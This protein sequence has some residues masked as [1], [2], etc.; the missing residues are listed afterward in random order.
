MLFRSL[1]PKSLI[2]EAKRK[3]IPNIEEITE[4]QDQLAEKLSAKVKI[5]HRDTGKGRLEISY[6]DIDELNRLLELF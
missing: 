5:N 6:N 2:S 4:K 1:V 3:A